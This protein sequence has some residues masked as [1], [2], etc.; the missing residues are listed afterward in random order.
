[1]LTN[2]ALLN[3]G[4]ESFV[5]FFNIWLVITCNT[6]RQNKGVEA[7]YDYKISD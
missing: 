4:Q 2:A 3:V 6:M 7:D 5:F 1:M